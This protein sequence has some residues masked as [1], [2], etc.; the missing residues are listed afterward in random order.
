MASLPTVLASEVM[1]FAPL[2]SA[3][4]VETPLAS[5]TTV[6]VALTVWAPLAMSPAIRPPG[7][8]PQGINPDVGPRPLAGGQFQADID[9]QR[10]STGGERDR[11]HDRRQHGIMARSPATPEIVLRTDEIV[12]RTSA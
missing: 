10:G 6:D 5:L 1:F 2:A 8:I 11:A 4:T 7:M 3:T 12:F 9:D